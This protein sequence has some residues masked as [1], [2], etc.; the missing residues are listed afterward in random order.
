MPLIIITGYPCSGKTYRAAQLHEWFSNELSSLQNS[1]STSPTSPT[2]SSPSP[3]NPTPYILNLTVPPPIS[4]HSLSLPPTVY[5]SASLEKAARAAEYSAVKR[6]LSHNALVIADGLNYIK[7]Y[8]YQL[9]CEAKA[10]GTPSCVVHVAASEEECI[11]RNEAR[12]QRRE[13]EQEPEREREGEAKEEADIE[14]N[15]TPPT[16]PFSPSSTP[17]PYDPP[18]L[19]NL[20]YRYE[21]PTGLTRWDRPLFTLP[22]TDPHPP[23]NLIWLALIGPLNTGLPIKRNKAT[24]LPPPTPSS[25]SSS[26]TALTTATTSVIATISQHY[27]DNPGSSSATLAIPACA[28]RLELPP[29]KPS[30]GQLQRLRRQ[31]EGMQRQGGPGAGVVLRPMGEGGER[32]VEGFVAF[33]NGV[34]AEREE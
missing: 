13:Q 20:L 14:N 5:A 25:S 29:T 2:T 6:A 11:K 23:Y 21:E 24:L 31:F 12:L 16:N 34:W 30:V 32:W 28:A 10:V 18:L 1:S 26:L 19:L 4:P 9:Y 15:P 27:A 7:G 33:L 17:P 8:R 22:T 3:T